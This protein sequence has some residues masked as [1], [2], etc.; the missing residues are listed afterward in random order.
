MVKKILSFFLAVTV[1]CVFLLYGQPAEKADSWALLKELLMM[2][3]VSGYEKGIA[4]YIQTRFPAGVE[5]QRD[6]MNNVWFSVG[7]GSPHLVFVAHSD[8]LG[9][10]IEKITETGTLKVKG[11]GGFFPQMYE[12]RPIVVYLEAGEVNGIVM[13]RPDY[14]SRDKEHSAL[15]LE[16]IEIY[17]GVSTAEEARRLGVAVG[18][19]IT[20]RKK[21]IE[22]SSDLLAA[23]AVDD[24]AGCAAMLAAA[25]KIDW[26]ELKGKKVTFAWDVQE[27][28]GLRGASRLAKILKADYVF[29]VDTFVSSDGPQDSRRFAWLRLGEGM[30]LRGIDS[31]SIAPRV[32]LKKLIAIARSH[33]IPYQLGNTRGG[34]DGSAFV[35]EG[36]VDLPLSWPGVYSHSFIEKINRH[37][38]A[39]LT[40]LIVAIV[41]DW[42]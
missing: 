4:D 25:Q 6:E 17:L 35:P 5:V 16:E 23:R 38:L 20:I 15:T 21:I 8:E 22:L 40:E 14:L 28:T 10:V 39:A 32:E 31:S 36:A 2:P 41:Q 33:D 3:G 37:D 11:R 1:I 34:N 29:P 26:K 27:E 9:L 12:G 42:E 24:R 7:N 19:Q 18:N 30:V 13:P